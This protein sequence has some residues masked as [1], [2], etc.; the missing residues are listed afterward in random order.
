MFRMMR[1]LYRSD[2]PTHSTTAIHPSQFLCGRGLSFLPSTPY[3][4]FP[5]H[6]NTLVES[7]SDH[8][9][10]FFSRMSKDETKCL[11]V[12]DEVDEHKDVVLLD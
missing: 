3:H 12:R 8:V 5:H 1:N 11:G 2:S 4:C 7:S 10:V 9:S 6:E